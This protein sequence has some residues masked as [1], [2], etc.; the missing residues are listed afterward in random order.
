M[1]FFI[2]AALCIATLFVNSI[3]NS[4]RLGVTKKECPDFETINDILGETH[5]IFNVVSALAMII[6]PSAILIIAI[7]NVV[8]LL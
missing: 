8:A 6:C 5:P 4:C 2:I 1:T 3:M 7:A